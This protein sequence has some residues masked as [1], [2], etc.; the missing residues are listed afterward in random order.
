MIVLEILLISS[1]LI[2]SSYAGLV[3]GRLYNLYKLPIGKNKTNILTM[4]EMRFLFG[5][6]KVMAMFDFNSI[7]DFND[8]DENDRIYDE[9]FYNKAMKNL[10]DN[11]KAYK[12]NWAD[13]I[14][15]KFR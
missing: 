8:I 1:I 6:R 13:H 14:W 2:L 5:D 3:L 11:N 15:P 4:K 12:P 10:L 7:E 9:D